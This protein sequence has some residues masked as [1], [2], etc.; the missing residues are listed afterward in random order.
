MRQDSAGR[1]KNLHPQIDEVRSGGAIFE[2]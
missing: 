2:E 1:K